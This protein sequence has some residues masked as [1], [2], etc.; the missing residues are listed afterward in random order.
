VKDLTKEERTKRIEKLEKQSN[1]RKTYKASV[2]DRKLV[3]FN[4]T[5]YVE[6]TKIENNHEIRKLRKL[7]KNEDISKYEEV[8]EI[9]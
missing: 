4:N 8:E 7:K 6:Y 3:S 1:Y 2:R 5:Y 9:S